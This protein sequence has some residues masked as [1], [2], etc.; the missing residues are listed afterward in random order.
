VV[1]SS[2]VNTGA[3]L[4]E[5]ETDLANPGEYRDGSGGWHGVSGESC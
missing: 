3:C 1:R 4:G 5:F 2:V